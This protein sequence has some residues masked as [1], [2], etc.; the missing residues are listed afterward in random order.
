MRKKFLFFNLLIF[1]LIF[2]LEIKVFDTPNDAG[3]SLTILITEPADVDYY[4]IYRKEE[5]KD[6]MLV[7]KLTK[8]ERCFLDDKVVR[9]KTYAYQVIGVKDT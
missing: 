4:Q 3:N 8:E 7:G 6:F 1:G 2:S 9:N 5:D